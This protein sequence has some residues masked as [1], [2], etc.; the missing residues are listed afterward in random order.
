MPIHI[1]FNIIYAE[2]YQEQKLSLINH[3]IISLNAG[4]LSILGPVQGTGKFDFHSHFHIIELI[5]QRF[6]W[7]WK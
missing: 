1:W 3:E 7:E 4:E 2:M 5:R 6:L